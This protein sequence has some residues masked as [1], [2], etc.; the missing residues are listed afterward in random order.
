[1]SLDCSSL[2]DLEHWFH[3]ISIINWSFCQELFNFTLSR[4]HIPLVALPHLLLH[5]S[6]TSDPAKGPPL[7]LYESLRTPSHLFGSPAFLGIPDLSDPCTAPISAVMHAAK[8]GSPSDHKAQH[9]AVLQACR[10]QDQSHNAGQQLNT[11]LGTAVSHVGKR[12]PGVKP[13]RGQVH[14]DQHMPPR[15]SGAPHSLTVMLV[16][17]HL[18]WHHVAPGWHWGRGRRK[19]G[20]GSG[21]GKHEVE[22]IGVDQRMM[23][24][25]QTHKKGGSVGG[26]ERLTEKRMK[27]GCSN[28]EWEK[29]HAMCTWAP[30]GGW[31]AE[32]KKN[33]HKRF[34]PS[35][36]LMIS[37][38]VNQLKIRGRGS[39]VIYDG[40]LLLRISHTGVYKL[41]VLFPEQISC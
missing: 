11:G 24:A 34:D 22:G 40:C 38:L 10:G 39:H 21:A 20:W 29:I 36:L 4:I 31:E 25:G 18:V 7:A 2:N 1:M 41:A 32:D 30:S 13:Y 3:I 8:F 9:R 26:M 15:S 23:K 14:M 5:P 12:V 6:H 35:L 16:V 27:C 19:G 17:P 37:T 33:C 28:V